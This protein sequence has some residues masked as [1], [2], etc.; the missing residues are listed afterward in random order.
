ML[1]SIETSDQTNSTDIED[2][3]ANPLIYNNHCSCINI[4]KSFVFFL[5]TFVLSLIILLIIIYYIR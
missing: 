3:Y 4:C 5:C 1:E 2:E